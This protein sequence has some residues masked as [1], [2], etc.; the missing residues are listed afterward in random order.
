MTLVSER[1]RLPEPIDP[2]SGG[3]INEVAAIDEPALADAESPRLMRTAGS[4][5]FATMVS[6]I[7]GFIKQILLLALL[8]GSV[9][10]SFTVAN[11][12]PNMISELV[13]GAVLTMSVVPVLVRAEKEDDDRGALFIRRLFTMATFVLV[14][15]TAIGLL[16]VPLLT[17]KVFLST[18]GKVST[19]LTELLTYLLLPSIPFYGLTALFIAILNTKEIFK[20]G[21]WA[22]VLNNIVVIATLLIYYL[23]P[24]TV[25]LTD[26]HIGDPK[27]LLLGLGSTFGVVVQ[28]LVL[29]PYFRARH[30]SLKP[31]WGLDTRLRQFGGMA[32]AFMLYVLISQAGFVFSTR[33]SSNVDPAGPAIYNNAWL[34]LQVPYGIL[35]VT[36]LTTLMPRISRHAADGDDF[37]VVND[38]SIATRMTMIT[39][40]PVIALLTV[41]GPAIGTAVY[42]YGNFGAADAHTLGEAIAYS[43]FTLIPYSFVLIHLR[44]FYARR[45]PWLPL[46]IVTAITVVKSALSLLAE[47]VASNAQDVVILLGVA[48][49]VGYAMGAFAGWLILRRSLDMSGHSSQRTFYL[50]TLIASLAG[51]LAFVVVE[52]LFGLVGIHHGDGPLPS[53]IVAAVGGLLGLVAAL[54]GLYL[55]KIP[56]V[57]DAT[58]VI[59]NRLA[60]RRAPAPEP[61]VAPS[62]HVPEEHPTT[63]MPR[64][65]TAADANGREMYWRSGRAL[66]PGTWLGNRRFRL[67]TPEGGSGA[68]S[69][70]RGFDHRLQRN[71]AI[72]VIDHDALLNRMATPAATH[73]RL[74]RRNRVVAGITGPAVTPIVDV[75]PYEHGTLVISEWNRGA[76]L[77]KSPIRTAA[78]VV[79]AVL[80]LADAA[81]VAQQHRVALGLDSVDRL[82]INGDGRVVLAFQGVAINDGGEDVYQL[83]HALR[84]LCNGVRESSKLRDDLA[85]LADQTTSGQLFPYTATGFRDAL[86]ARAG[87]PVRREPHRQR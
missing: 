35:G 23:A 39:L 32:F 62:A 12:I 68:V 63:Q 52:V 19:Q 16:L 11:Q 27:L 79:T 60:A 5:A 40:L 28:V 71:V 66:S 29:L 80:P 31:L 49:G 59:R 48:N 43:A 83:G 85:A 41:A 44:I 65:R 22:P 18:D 36:V 14:V 7:T 17:T 21:A 46:F 64:V 84:V 72:T 8:G 33:I 42:G 9:A 2:A 61:V 76:R 70:W 25:N 30:I 74:V 69:L 54:A 56:E 73:D 51:A 4:V 10:S 47:V 15:A 58:A 3:P 13:L 24:G 55:L 81:V 38:M 26:I 87:L 53:L 67:L 37:A 77:N 45:E 86:R 20:P 57:M 78:N 82:R 6:R 50:K 34:F 1:E 75:L